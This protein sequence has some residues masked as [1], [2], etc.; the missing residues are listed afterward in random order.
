MAHH[1]LTGATV[2]WAGNSASKRSKSVATIRSPVSPYFWQ[3]TSFRAL[4]AH[5]L[6]R[7]LDVPAPRR[8]GPRVWDEIS[9]HAEG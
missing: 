2:P 5:D 6:A 7:A 8:I 9:P 1:E 4:R 3:I